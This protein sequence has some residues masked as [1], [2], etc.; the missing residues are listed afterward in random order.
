MMVENERLATARVGGKQQ[1]VRK[2]LL[3][4]EERGQV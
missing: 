2:M 4:E 3:A 1:G